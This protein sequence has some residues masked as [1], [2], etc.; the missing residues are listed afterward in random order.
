MRLFSSLPCRPCDVLVLWEWEYDIDFLELLAERSVAA[1]LTLDAV[2][3]PSPATVAKLLD[4][5][6][7]PALLLDRASDHN[8]ELIPVLEAFKA[9][10]VRVAND[11]ARMIWAR[12]KATMHLE[13]VAAGVSVPYAVI[14]TSEGGAGP[15]A[16]HPDQ[17]EQLGSPFVIKPATG[18][19]GEGVVLDA[20]SSSDV[21][22]YLRE[23]GYDKVLLQHLVEP[24][25]VGG[26]RGWFRVFH[27]D[28]TIVPCWWDDQTHEYLELAH[29]DEATEQLSPL[30]E[31]TSLIARISQVELFTTEIACDLEGRF[32]VVDFVNEMPD[33]R[34]QSRF[35]DGVPDRILEL[36]ARKL[37]GLALAT[38]QGSAPLAHASCALP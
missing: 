32:V 1:R 3:A 28:G 5:E 14:I 31:I 37:V 20:R 4:K 6:R 25:R 9:R 12:D 15:D 23:T 21:H 17:H 10:G 26:R 34:P 24:R 2:S 18:G 29:Y 38:R 27:I 35:R 7:L 22:A 33:L 36:I 8:P 13:L 19:G 11:A 30:R 16:L